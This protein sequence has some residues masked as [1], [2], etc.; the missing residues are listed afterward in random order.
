VICV[1]ASAALPLALLL[2]CVDVLD[3]A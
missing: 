2:E 3:M 1:S